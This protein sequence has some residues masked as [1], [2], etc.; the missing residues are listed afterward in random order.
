MGEGDK[1]SCSVFPLYLLKNM[2]A[3]FSKYILFIASVPKENNVWHI[4]KSSQPQMSW[5]CVVK[6]SFLWTWYESENC[7][8]WFDCL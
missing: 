5:R 3:L 6:K 8:T 4:H 7:D 2:C 1:H